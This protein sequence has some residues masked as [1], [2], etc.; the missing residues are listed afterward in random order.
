MEHTSWNRLCSQMMT[1]LHVLG[2]ADP[3]SARLRLRPW[4]DRELLEAAAAR[5]RAVFGRSARADTSMPTLRGLLF[6]AIA[7]VGPRTTEPRRRAT[8]RR[9]EDPELPRRP[10]AAADGSGMGEAGGSDGDAL[11]A[12]ELDAEGQ[13][14]SSPARHGDR[15][16][17]PKL[18]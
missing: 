14:S 13:L 16:M 1:L 4:P 18:I 10:A 15:T 12:G 7:P 6:P 5:A 17:L 11:C 2:M 8:K 9:R 3:S